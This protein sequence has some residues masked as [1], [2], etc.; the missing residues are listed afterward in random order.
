MPFP[1][2]L[3]H[4]T[5]ILVQTLGTYIPHLLRWA[6]VDLTARGMAVPF[7]RRHVVRNSRS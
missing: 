4:I 5:T 3:S 2:D 1:G 6:Y 7:G